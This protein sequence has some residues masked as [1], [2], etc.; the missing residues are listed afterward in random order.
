MKVRWTGIRPLILHNARLA[1][2][3]DEYSARL[4]E[5]TKSNKGKNKT[6]ARD[7]EIARCEWE[8]GLYYDSELGP[9]VPADMIE[10]AIQNGGK[11][12]SA[13]KQI[14]AAVFCT[15]ESVMVPIQYKGPRDL[16]GLYADPAFRMR[17]SV[18]VG[19][20]RVMRTRPMFPTGWKLEFSVEFDDSV[21][22]ANTVLRAMQDAGR[23]VGLGDWRPKFGRFLVEV[24]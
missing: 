23:L 2:P 19:N 5:L 14:Q 6:Q 3:M 8:G 4:K 24:L 15:E 7:A 13:G 16:D 12:C 9:Y 1:D 22:D 17:K 11:K 21:V 20:V 18:R 10:S